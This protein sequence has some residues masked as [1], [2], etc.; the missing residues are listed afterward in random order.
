MIMSKNWTLLC[1]KIGHR[2]FDV[3]YQF[4]LRIVFTKIGLTRGHDMTVAKGFKK[5]ELKRAIAASSELGLEIRQAEIDSD[6]T[7]RLTYGSEQPRMR[8]D[9]DEK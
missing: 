6:G 9:W 1:P 4:V 3:R 5:T 8:N 2:R 7:I